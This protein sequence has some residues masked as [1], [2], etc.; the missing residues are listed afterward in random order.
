MTSSDD[1]RLVAP[2]FT[3]FTAT[4][5]RAHTLHRV[6]DSLRRQTFRDFEWLVVDDGSSDGTAEL[7]QQWQA[8]ADFPIRYEYKPNGGKHTAWN[9]GV[10]LARGRFFLSLDSDDACVPEALQVFLEAWNGIPA[11]EREHF[12]GVCCL[13]ADQ[14]GHV[15]GDR[16]PQDVFDSDSNAIRYKHRVSGEKWGFHRIEV[17]REFP[18]PEMDG[19]SYVPESIVWGRIAKRYKERFIN[20]VLRI[21][22]QEASEASR[23]TVAPMWKNS[24]ALAY[25]LRAALNERLQWF[26]HEPR[27]FLKTAANL[28]RVSWHAGQGVGEQYRQLSSAF[29]RLLWAAMMPAGRVLYLRDCRRR[30]RLAR[31]AMTAS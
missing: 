31:A 18:F 2:T 29:A 4:Y 10:Q 16:F 7:V 28:S 25:G 12:T 27:Y 21:Y 8:E 6:H 23:L 30:D 22:H 1:P 24:A 26:F 17:A 14:N 19:V 9:R 13:A 15:A 20:R 5:N 11:G 3:V